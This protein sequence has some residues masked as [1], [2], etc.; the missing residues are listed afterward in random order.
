MKIYQCMRCGLIFK[1][2]KQVI[3]HLKNIEKIS[4]FA[5]DYYYQTFNVSLKDAE[6]VV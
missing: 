4:E 3:A 2:K 6:K 5:V 1:T